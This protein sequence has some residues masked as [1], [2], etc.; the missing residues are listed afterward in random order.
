[1]A[2]RLAKTFLEAIW[3]HLRRDCRA[4]GRASPPR[5]GRRDQN[6][7][8]QLARQYEVERESFREH[9]ELL[10]LGWISQASVNVNASLVLMIFV[11]VK[12]DHRLA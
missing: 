7:E 4:R 12:A 5:C 3:R 6:V 9:N 8:R 1:L 11:P 2:F 10:S